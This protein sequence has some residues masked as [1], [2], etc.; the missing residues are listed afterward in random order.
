MKVG[1]L[2]RQGNKVLEMR[3]G[4]KRRSPPKVLGVV[5]EIRNMPPPR[6]EETEQLRSLM[7]MVGRQVDVLWA[8][9]KLSKNF[10]ENS[11]EVVRGDE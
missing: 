10:A 2:V 3:R 6:P 5:V 8:N 7:A 9:G 11:L 4:G 1:D